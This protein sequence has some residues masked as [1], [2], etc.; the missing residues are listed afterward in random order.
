MGYSWKKGLW[1]GALIWVIMFA[2]VSVFVAFKAYDNSAAKTI[3]VL[4]GGFVAYF[5]VLK[6]KPKGL[7]VCLWYAL[8]WTAVGLVLDVL[9]TTRFSPHIFKAPSL[10]AGYGLMFLVVWFGRLLSLDKLPSRNTSDSM[11]LQ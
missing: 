4:I 9:I 10:W 6:V 5:A 8:S 11:K 3:I 7:M 2:V 1:V